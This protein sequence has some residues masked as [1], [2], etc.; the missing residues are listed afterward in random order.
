MMNMSAK[1]DIKDLKIL[2]ELEK[3]ARQSFGQ[4]A[5]KTGMS[6]EVVLYRVR[7]MEKA[8]VIRGFTT[9]IDLYLLGFRL[10]PV[11]IKFEELSK[12][13]ES[14]MEKYLNKSRHIGWAARCEGTWDLNIVLRVR[15]AAEIAEFFDGFEARFGNL[16]LDKTLMHTVSLNYFK[17]DFLPRIEE[18]ELVRT[19][20]VADVTKLT[21]NEEKLLR[22]LSE[23]SRMPIGELAREAGVSPPTAMAIL[24][25]LETR[26][27]IQ[28]YRVFTSF[29]ALGHSYYKIWLNLKGM[30]K[31][32]WEAL[33][34][35]LGFDP[36]VVWAT[37]TIGYYDFSIELEVPDSE[38]LVEFIAK[39]KEKFH[40]KVRKRDML[41]IP[42]EM[43]TSYF[44]AKL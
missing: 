22:A 24:R 23:N 43:A 3:D 32:D 21:Q 18:R 10:Y 16:I 13:E 36:Y 8:G 2:H 44:P 35:F 34:T 12:E 28:G 15:N 6:K 26:K 7:T 20:E 11:L 17:R 19:Q 25:R 30:K 29:R 40:D 38:A 41:S 42:K 14:D 39:F 9:E 31:K 37:R 5:K 4:I 33:Y 1:S 27:I